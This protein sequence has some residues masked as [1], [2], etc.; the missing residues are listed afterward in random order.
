[1]SGE[2]SLAPRK[3]EKGEKVGSRSK[4]FRN[5]TFSAP[6]K[7]LCDQEKSIDFPSADED[8]GGNVGSDM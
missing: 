3:S 6:V 8:S 4:S 7:A 1:L 2:T 5:G